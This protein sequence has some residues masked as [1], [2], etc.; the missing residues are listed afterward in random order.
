MIGERTPELVRHL[1]GLGFKTAP[2]ADDDGYEGYVTLLDED[3]TYFN[4]SRQ[5]PGLLQ[6]IVVGPM[7]KTAQDYAEAVGSDYELSESA[8]LPGS[9]DAVHKRVL[10]RGF[11]SVVLRKMVRADGIE[12]PTSSV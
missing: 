2:N 10:E 12:P 1:N 6:I 3:G 8:P 5:Q 9:D 7:A 11:H 4:F